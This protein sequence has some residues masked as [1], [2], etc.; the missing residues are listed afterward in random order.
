M[1][2]ITVAMTGFRL[3]DGILLI[4]IWSNQ[5]DSMP[6]DEMVTHFDNPNSLVDSFLVKLSTDDDHKFAGKKKD[7]G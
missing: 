4:G 6:R 1:A 3:S 5:N 2:D 7:F